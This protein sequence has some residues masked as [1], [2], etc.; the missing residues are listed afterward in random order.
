VPELEVHL[1]SPIREVWSGPA[2]MV[3]ARGTEGEVGVLAGH[4]PMLLRL[5]IGPLRIQHQGG[6]QRAV[7]DGGFLHVTT[8]EDRTR[9]DVLADH[10]ELEGDIDFEAAERARVEAE[11][12]LEQ[13]DDALIQGEL[14]KATARLSL[15]G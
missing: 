14:A 15:R 3:I 8:T 6:E 7:V 5:A 10:A 2:T 1:V 12:R 9:V 4:A 11:R 13:T